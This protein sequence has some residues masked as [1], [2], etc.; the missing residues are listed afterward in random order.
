[1][2]VRRS[3]WMYTIPLLAVLFFHLEASARERQKVPIKEILAAATAE[4]ELIERDY[5]SKLAAENAK[6]DPSERMIAVTL[7][8]GLAPGGE[9]THRVKESDRS[10]QEKEAIEKLERE[11][12]EVNKAVKRALANPN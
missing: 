11:W 7:G 8:D 12:K 3:Q 5:R 2:A 6:T 9:L 4:R 10:Y 1:M